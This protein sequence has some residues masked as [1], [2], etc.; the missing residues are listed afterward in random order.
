MPKSIFLSFFN[1]IYTCTRDT[2]LRDFQFR[3][4][5]NA[6]ITNMKLKEWN[7]KDDNLCNFCNREPETL[8]HLLLDCDVSKQI[9]QYVYNFI[10]ELSGTRIHMN[11]EEIMLG[12]IDKP[13]AVFFNNVHIIVKQYLYACRCLDKRPLNGV[14]IEKIKFGRK[15]EHLLAVKCNKVDSWNQKWSFLEQLPI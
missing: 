12:I 10:Y 7:I 9:W 15:I 4:L 14:I 2:K 1:S 5:H 6:V 13:F 3:V 8:I 11:K